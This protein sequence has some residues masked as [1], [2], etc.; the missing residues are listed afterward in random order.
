[1]MQSAFN[2]RGDRAD[3]SRW[4]EVEGPM[5]VSEYSIVTLK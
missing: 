4:P 3:P 1:M 2:G 5:T